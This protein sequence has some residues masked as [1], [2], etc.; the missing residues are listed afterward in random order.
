MAVKKTK[1]IFIF[2]AVFFLFINL[3]MAQFQ[4]FGELKGITFK[5]FED[6]L[7]VH[8]EVEMPFEYKIF[9]LSDPNRL[10]I[11]LF[12]VNKF[13]CDS[14]IEVADFG[15]KAIR[16]A[17]N[18]PEVTRIVF[19]F[20]EKPPSYK[21]TETSKGLMAVFWFEEEKIEEKKEIAEEKIPVE[22]EKEIIKKE[23]IK[24]KPV[25]ETPPPIEK[26][27]IQE[28][29][30]ILSIGLKAG[31]QFMHALHFQDVYGKSSSFTGVEAVFKFPL[32][33]KDYV[34]ISLGFK[35]ISDQGGSGFEKSDLEITPISF[36]A[37][38][39]RQYGIFSPY[40]GLGAD[41]YNYSENSPETFEAPLYSRKTWGG[42]IQAGTDVDLTPFL[43][44]RLFFKYHSARLKENGIDINLGGNAYGLGLAY[45]FN[46]KI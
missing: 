23:E 28:E 15:I 43:S 16:V 45:H 30:L 2:W 7:E 21:I 37:F 9:V 12:Q 46:L 41:H 5:R 29:N 26:E 25:V 39:S 35:F 38:Y 42:H 31:F 14:Y 17:K 22:K 10:V 8:M 1:K 4:I 27:V 44:L 32:R 13:S 11:D 6:K 18:Q 24:E 40:V 36:S 19:D 3:S 34:G 20:A 33:K